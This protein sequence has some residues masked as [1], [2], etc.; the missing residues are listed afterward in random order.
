MIVLR[1]TVATTRDNDSIL[2]DATSGGIHVIVIYGVAVKSS[3]SP[4]LLIR[5]LMCDVRIGNNAHHVAYFDSLEVN[6]NRS[7]N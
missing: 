4:I 1:Y 7:S 6:K 3:R 2:Y 5:F